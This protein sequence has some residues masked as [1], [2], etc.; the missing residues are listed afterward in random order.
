VAATSV[1]GAII[2]KSVR[3]PKTGELIADHLRGR[4]V[5][6][7]LAAGD[8]L[9]SEVELMEQFD[10]SRPTL[11]EAFRILETESLILIKRGARGARVISPSVSVAARYIGVLLQVDNVTIGDVYEARAQLEPAAAGLLA[12]RRTKQDLSKLTEA[13]DELERLV[14]AKNPTAADLDDWTD[15]TQR[16]HE[17]VVDLAGNKTLSLQS[18]VLREVVATHLSVAVHRTYEADPAREV[19]AFRRTARSYRKLIELVDGRDTAG[20]TKHWKLHM[21]IAGLSLLGEGLGTQ[22]VVDLFS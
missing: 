19:K 17:L 5:R 6:G 13:A 10:V 14:A 8:S 12:A 16:F 21:E 18:R 4:I 7:E 3:A 15:S 2:G 1:N 22:T 9:P 11:R 20:A